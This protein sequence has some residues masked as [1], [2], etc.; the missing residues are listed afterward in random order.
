MKLNITTAAE[1]KKVI[2]QRCSEIDMKEMAN[3]VQPLLFN[4]GDIK[5]VLLFP[6]FLAH[7]NLR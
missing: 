6:D 7:V 3:D 5:K 4:P 2:L 1:I